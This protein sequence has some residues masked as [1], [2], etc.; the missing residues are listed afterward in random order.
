MITNRRENNKR[1]LYTGFSVAM[2]IYALIGVFG[3]IGILG[4]DTD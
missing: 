2:L 1:D 4:R 3:T